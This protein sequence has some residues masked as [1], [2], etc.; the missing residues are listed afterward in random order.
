MKNK[1]TDNKYGQCHLI[2]DKSVVFAAYTMTSPICRQKTQ[3]G[4]VSNDSDHVLVLFLS[5]IQ[6]WVCGNFL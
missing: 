4:Y 6:T 3:T 2:H 1:M 5:Y